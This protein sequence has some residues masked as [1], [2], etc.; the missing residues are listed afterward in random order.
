MISMFN[1]LRKMSWKFLRKFVVPITLFRLFTINVNIDKESVTRIILVIRA[2]FSSLYLLRS[3]GTA[4]A[5]NV[6][7]FHGINH[8]KQYSI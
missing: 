3:A 7:M 2:F 8:E 5:V 4:V 6:I 1:A